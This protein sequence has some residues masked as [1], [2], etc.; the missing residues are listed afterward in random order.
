MRR[1]VSASPCER[2]SPPV[3]ARPVPAGS[4]ECQVSPG[5][6]LAALVRSRQLLIAAN[7]ADRVL[8][9]APGH[10]PCPTAAGSSRRKS[11]AQRRGSVSQRLA[12]EGA[13][14]ATVGSGRRRSRRRWHSGGGCCGG[15]LGNVQKPPVG[16]FRL[17][18]PQSRGRL[19][20]ALLIDSVCVCLSFLARFPQ[21]AP[22][23]W[24]PPWAS[25]LRTARRLRSRAPPASRRRCAATEAARLATGLASHVTGAI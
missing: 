23:K 11:E 7:I 22:R 9:R 25:R 5:R 2:S 24:A 8:S 4:R 21:R 10:R 18:R 16:C 12:F 19:G 14:P 6:V 3:P 13:L 20:R 17:G 1:A 15:S